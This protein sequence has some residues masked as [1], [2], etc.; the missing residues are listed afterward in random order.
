[1]WVINTGENT[2]QAFTFRLTAGSIKTI[3]RAPRADF[4]VDAALVS[5]VHCRLS[6]GAA[7]LEVVDLSST[8]G[9]FVNGA[10]IDRAVLKTGDTLAVG[11]VQFVVS[12]PT[13][14]SVTQ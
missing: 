7:D 2:D 9:T 14:S 10:R 3:G 13:D 1:M 6:A 8:N 5:R 4:I 11:K 12:R